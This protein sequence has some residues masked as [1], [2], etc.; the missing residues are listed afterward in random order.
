MPEPRRIEIERG[1]LQWLAGVLGVFAFSEPMS[2]ED[3]AEHLPGLEL[4][5]WPAGTP[6]IR[7][8]EKGADL[9]I[10]FSG[11]VSV[12]RRGRC[13]AELQEGAILGEV[14]LVMRSLRTAT[15]LA[16][17]Q[18]EV[19]RIPAIDK[20]LRRF[21]SLREFLQ[22]T[23]HKRLEE[24]QHLASL[25]GRAAP[26]PLPRPLP[27]ASRAAPQPPRLAG[28]Y[29]VGDLIGK[30][31]MGEVFSGF[32]HSLRRRIALKRLHPDIVDNPAS[33]E[34]FIQEARIV[35]QLSHPFIVAIHDILTERGLTYLVLEYVDGRNLAELL[36]ER[37]RLTLAECRMI[38]SSACQAVACAHWN[39]ILH[40]DLKP[41]NIM[42]TRVGYVKVMDFGLARKVKDAR[43]RMS[44]EEPSGTPAY[45]AP[46]QHLGEAGPASDVYALGECLYE[47]LTGRI[48]FPGPDFL[49]QKQRLLL[50]PARSLVPALPA[51][52]DELLRAALSPDPKDRIPGALQLLQRLKQL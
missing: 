8:G 21:S 34:A 22:E 51:S 16:G 26:A 19:F 31:G 48:P 40:R 18:C 52:I 50:A 44:S 38:L 6:L 36:Q 11:S 39:R 5:Q 12:Q 7:E 46:E 15:V 37:K 43:A 24:L 45:M 9:H 13:I 41:S 29:E 27:A 2:P 23:A 17:P 35:A 49:G 14:A 33:R 25:T 10:V 28:R 47:M 30:G 4:L 1:H 42:I 20:L 32:D 3:L